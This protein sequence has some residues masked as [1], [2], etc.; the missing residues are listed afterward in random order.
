M[1]IVSG[2]VR[3]QNPFALERALAD[4]TFAGVKFI[5]HVLAFAV[6][7]SAQQLH[8]RLAVVALI[9]V[10]HALLCVYQRGQLRQYHP[11]DGLHVALT[12]QHSCKS[13]EIGFEPI[14]L[15]VLLSSVFEIQNHLVDI[16]FQRRDLALC[17]HG[18]RSRQVAFGHRRRHFSD[19]AHL[20]GQVG[21]KAVDVVG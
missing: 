21:R 7:I 11:G 8:D 13:R 3:Y 14:L 20:V 16:V 18:D 15:G 5:C 6:G 9:Y 17:F 4:E 2:N 10:E 19:G 12:L 1:H